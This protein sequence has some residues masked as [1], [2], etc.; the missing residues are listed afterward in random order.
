MEELIAF[1]LEKRFFGKDGKTVGK[2]F[3]NEKLPVVL[4][5]KLDCTVLQVGWRIAPEV[6]GNVKN[7]AEDASYNLA[8]GVWR[9]LEME[10]ADNTVGR[11]TLIVL[12]ET[13]AVTVKRNRNKSVEITL[14]ERFKEITSAV[15]E[16]LRFQYEQS[17]YS[18]F[19][20]LHLVL[21]KFRSCCRVLKKLYK[22]S[23]I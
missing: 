11:E 3:G 10:T 12:N 9:A 23:E 16:N 14:R 2:A 8:L 5:G 6:N 18:G 4:S 7:L 15:L 22:I 13:D 19:Y 1:V 20:Y 17:L 21:E